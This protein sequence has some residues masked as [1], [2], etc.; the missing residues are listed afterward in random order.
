VHEKKFQIFPFFAGKKQSSF[1]YVFEGHHTACAVAKQTTTEMKRMSTLN[2]VFLMGNLTRDPELRRT[3]SGSTLTSFG[4]A[5]NESYKDK[6]GQAVERALF[7][8]V[9][10]WGRQAESCA[11]YMKK[12]SPVLV[13]GKLR[14]EQWETEEKQKRSKHTVQATRVAF[15]GRREK[16]E[17]APER[18]TEEEAVPFD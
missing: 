7:I 4:L 1:L 13:E 17:K 6:E 11:E 9:V 8:D 15:I 3:P 2:H 18:P 5:V 14:L 16:S 10:T 12:G